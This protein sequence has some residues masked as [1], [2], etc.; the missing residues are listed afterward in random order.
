MKLTFF[1]ISRRYRV[2]FLRSC[3]RYRQ[4][5]HDPHISHIIRWHLNLPLN[6]TLN[7]I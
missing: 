6:L 7:L 4:P 2:L 3:I 1:L 5:S